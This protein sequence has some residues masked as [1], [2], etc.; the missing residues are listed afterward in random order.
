MSDERAALTVLVLEDDDQIREAL[1]E[2]L[3][4]E[5]FVASGAVYV[6]EALEIAL[7][8]R[9]DAVV[10]DLR[11]AD[12]ESGRDFI[13]R[14]ADDPTA[15]AMVVLTPSNELGQPI[16]AEF[17]LPWLTKPFDL[18]DLVVMIRRA[19]ASHSRPSRPRPIVAA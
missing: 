8:R 15:P 17:G 9:P 6:R 2:A 19:V 5:G 18:D 10:V 11:L 3:T 16:G 13:A 7:A 1:V 14:F 4:L 12:G